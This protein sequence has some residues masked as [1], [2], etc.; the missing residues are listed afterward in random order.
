MARKGCN[1]KP[2]AVIGKTGHASVIELI[3][4]R[5]FVCKIGLLDAETRET[6][7]YM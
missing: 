4:L 1:D 7:R 6:L 5:A 2:N 3:A